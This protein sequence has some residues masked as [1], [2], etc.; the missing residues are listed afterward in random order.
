MTVRTSIA[1]VLLLFTL[2]ANAQAPAASPEALVK[3]YTADIQ[4]E[5]M[6]VVS[7]YIHP[8]ELKRFKDL[9]MP[10]VRKDAGQKNEVIPGLFGAEATLASVEA[11]PA[12]QFMDGFMRIAGEQ[13]KEL[14]F[15]DCEIVGTV[16]EKDVTH[17]VTRVA[18]GIKGVQI[19]QMEV[20]S[21]KPFGKE[22]KLLL[23]G[24]LEGM[25]AAISAQQ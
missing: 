13:L 7:R 11:M 10:W 12:S 3:A 17:V 19:K 2:S 18:A 8:D 6:I 24:E 15:G 21:T 9:L 16:R 14:T 4:K 22:W 20:I 5:G 23:S 25:A 1:L